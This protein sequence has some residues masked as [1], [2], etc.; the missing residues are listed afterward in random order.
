MT[1][2]ID[3]TPGTV[4]RMYS[5]NHMPPQVVVAVEGDAVRCARFAGDHWQDVTYTKARL[6]VDQSRNWITP[7]TLTDDQRQSLAAYLSQIKTAV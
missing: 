1:N 2:Q 4:F 3:L 5:P 7:A 6:A